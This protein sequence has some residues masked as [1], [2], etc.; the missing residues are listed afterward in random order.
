MARSL[1]DMR[2]LGWSTGGQQ[3][4]VPA[5]HRVG[6]Y[7]QPDPVEQAAGELVQQGS[8][9]C[10]VTGR[11]PRPGPSKLPLQDRDLMGQHQDLGVLVQVACQQPQ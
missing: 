10:A 4:A 1:Q 3:V 5:Q 2:G 8:Q 7:Q 6:A 9:E 11:E